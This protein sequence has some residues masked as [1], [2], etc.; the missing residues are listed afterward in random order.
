MSD[1]DEKF[2][3]FVFLDV[4]V[5]NPTGV[6]WVTWETGMKFLKRDVERDG[7]AIFICSQNFS[8]DLWLK[9]SH[10]VDCNCA[11][12]WIIEMNLDEGDMHLRCC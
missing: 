8:L 2:K 3:V 1:L 9:C 4:I 12:I 7:F 6:S 10:H 5:C 11:D